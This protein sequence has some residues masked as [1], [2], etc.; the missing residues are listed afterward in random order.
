MRDGYGTGEAREGAFRHHIPAGELQPAH[1]ILGGR[2]AAAA[3]DEIHAH[4]KR[5]QR[6]IRYAPHHGAG[7]CRAG[8]GCAGPVGIPPAARGL[9]PAAG[10]ARY[11]LAQL[12]LTAGLVRRHPHHRVRAGGG[13][14][15]HSGRSQTGGAAEPAG[16]H[17]RLHRLRE[18]GH[19][20]GSRCSRS[21]GPHAG[22]VAAG[23]DVLGDSASAGSC[24][25]EHPHYETQELRRAEPPPARPYPPPAPP[26]ERAHDYPLL[27]LPR[28]QCLAAHRLAGIPARGARSAC[29][30]SRAGA[31]GGDRLPDSRCAAGRHAK[32]L[33]WR[34]S[35]S[36][37]PGHTAG[38][39][40]MLGAA[41]SAFICLAVGR[42][43]PGCRAGVHLLCGHVAH[44]RLAAG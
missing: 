2:P 21:G 39:S 37:S 5:K 26:T 40:G 14:R 16:A 6:V 33:A 3:G 44:S 29:I 7:H 22:R 4:G 20:G 1:G 24:F 18:P 15:C 42:H 31:F 9:C 27:P 34:H 13:G 12:G 17:E 23:V 10:H 32:P 28:G 25:V 36:H 35:P 11:H 41:G 43:V 8:G 30:R 38:R 19:C